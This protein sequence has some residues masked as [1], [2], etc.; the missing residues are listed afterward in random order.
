MWLD[1]LVAIDLKDYYLKS[2][3]S[4]PKTKSSVYRIELTEDKI[5][6]NNDKAK[7]YRAIK[8]TGRRLRPYEHVA[9]DLK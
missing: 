3:D 5:I 6:I 2:F 9:H 1:G 7:L 8:R 4:M